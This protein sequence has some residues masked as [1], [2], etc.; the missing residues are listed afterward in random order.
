MIWLFRLLLGYVNFEYQYGFR[1][2]FISD[3]FKNGLEIR[4]AAVTENGFTASCSIKTY[5]RLHTYAYRSGGRVRIT[6]KCGLPFLLH[7]IENRFGF[8][9]GAVAFIFIICLLTGFVWRVDYKGCNVVSEATLTQ[10]MKNN[11]LDTGAMWSSIDKDDLA[12]RLMRDFDEISWAHINQYGTTAV[13]EIN[14]ARPVPQ[15]NDDRL[16]GRKI[17]RRQLEVVAYRKQGDIKIKDIKCYKTL[18]FY[19]FNIPLYIS[20]KQGDIEELERKM[21][22]INN[23]ELPIG[24]TNATE[25]WLTYTDKELG[26]KEL[27]ALAKK[28]LENEEREQLDGFEIINRNM[29]LDID[30]DKCVIKCAYIIKENNK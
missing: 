27:K 11:G 7:P 4:N 23:T 24:I 3:C 22:K 12:A 16:K 19:F 28:K 29:T 25:K 6:K 1:E 5:K 9:T 17:F 18:H 15:P 21:V 30:K 26:D 20:K 13:V 2:D 14:E 10:Y 8:L